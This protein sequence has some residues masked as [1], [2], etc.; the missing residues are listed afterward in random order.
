MRRLGAILVLASLTLAG[1]AA[2]V[3]AFSG[4][5]AIHAD[6]TY[7]V[8]MTFSVALPGG[9]PDRLELLLQFEGSDATLVVP[10]AATGS[11]AT[12]RWDAAS[13]AVTPN[14]RITYRWRATTAGQTSLSASGSLL[15]DDDRAGLSWRS[16]RIG[17]A[18]VH[19]YGNNETEARRFG[20]LTA[21]AAGA[22]EALLG[23][24]LA[25]PIDIFVYVTRNDFFG[26]LGPGAREWTGA[27][28]YPELRTI[29]MWLGAG[30]TDY[31]DTTITHEVTHVV[32]EDAT[33]NPFHSPAKWFNE[34]FAT[35]AERQSADPQH[36]TVAGAASRG[37][38][39]AFDA[40]V[41]QFPIGGDAA[42]LS[43]AEGATMIQ[44]I[45]DRYGRGAI[46]RIA[47]AWKS[48]VTDA[49]ALEAGTGIPADQL[50]AAYF[51]SF[52]VDA[53]QPVTPA[54]IPSSNVDLPPQPAAA[55]PAEASTGGSPAPSN[56]PASGASGDVVLIAAFVALAVVALLL[57]GLAWRSRRGGTLP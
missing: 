40:I 44:L 16:A 1:L 39:L 10:V 47:A 5:G 51:A 49:E 43:Y 26:A 2:P 21:D 14:T 23:D 8:E 29:F 56:S 35:W 18:T 20:K 52:G 6:S 50:Y 15:Y 31:L 41:D 45:I 42:G 48:G 17:A 32:F 13:R 37:G 19:W 30:S 12:Y 11:S 7:G 34:G 4:F 36:A 57:G 38:L 25:G 3:H 55:S 33:A 9:P 27:A 24:S 53:P 46:A 22:A 28:T 54:P